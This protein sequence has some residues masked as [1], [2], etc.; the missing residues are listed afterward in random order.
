MGSFYYKDI[1]KHINYPE[2]MTEAE[3]RAKALEIHRTQVKSILSDAAQKYGI[4]EK[5]L[6]AQAEQESGLKPKVVS[7]A[8]AQGIMQLMPGTAKDLGV[9][10][11]TDINEN[12][13]AGARYLKQQHDK[14]GTWDKAL[15]AYNAGPGAVEKAGGIPKISETENYVKTILSNSGVDVNQSNVFYEP[16]LQRYIKIPSGM[17]KE[18]AIKRAQEHVKVPSIT[19][20]DKSDKFGGISEDPI[21]AQAKQLYEE[22]KGPGA[23]LGAAAQAFAQS[24]S[25]GAMP[26]GVAA[27][28][29][30]DYKTNVAIEKAVEKRRAQDNPISTT[31]GSIAGSMANPLTRLIGLIPASGTAANIGK[32]ALGGMFGGVESEF[33]ANPEAQAMDLLRSGGVGMGTGGALGATGSTLQ[34]IAQK[35]ATKRLGSP[36]AAEQALSYGFSKNAPSLYGKNQSFLNKTYSEMQ[37]IA[38][39]NPNAMV[40]APE[41]ITPGD[42]KA[43]AMK[44]LMSSEVAPQFDEATRLEAIGNKL[45]T[46]NN[47]SPEDAMIYQ[48]AL[49]AEGYS[50]AS[51]VPY[52]SDAA[53]AIQSTR[54]AQRQN[55]LSA[56]PDEEAARMSELGQD[57]G[58]GAALRRSFKRGTVGSEP[59]LKKDLNI[60]KF[61]VLPAI[62]TGGKTIVPTM[63]Y[64]ALQ[65]VPGFTGLNAVGQKLPNAA[66]PV[67]SPLINLIDYIMKQGS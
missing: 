23:P 22:R 56:L 58:Q 45:A 3:A 26:Y 32:G 60:D 63:G 35:F 40:S 36:E 54:A 42:I 10:D 13:D 38:K 62:F 28:D 17:T 34:G 20:P 9:K 7:S 37:D 21:Q 31:I 66:A 1:D 39:A 18:D 65:S 48:K 25:F 49:G 46:Q 44:R 67:T 2:G 33:A 24:A 53:K 19:P 64:K 6:I 27:L 8:G 15:A 50:P 29:K 47:F 52:S 11:I 41:N 51:G 59:A 30:G 12:I 4:P 5:L 57:Y 14:F 16:S 43:L 55:L 61:D